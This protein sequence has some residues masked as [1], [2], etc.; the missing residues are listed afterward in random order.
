MCHRSDFELCEMN[1]DSLYMGISSVNFEDII[2]LEYMSAYKNE[3]DESCQS[4]PST[5]FPRKC[6][7]IRI[8]YDRRQPGLFTVEHTCDEMISLCSKSHVCRS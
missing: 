5:F 1:T 2:K 4:T 8:A 7:D 3:V 6:C